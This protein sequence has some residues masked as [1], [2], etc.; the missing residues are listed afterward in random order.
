MAGEPRHDETTDDQVLIARIV[1]GGEPA[2]RAFESL[3]LKHRD[4]VVALAMRFTGDR[5]LALDVMQETFLYVVRKL[6]DP[7]F[8]LTG[9]FMT[10]LYPAVRH[11]SINARQKA[12]RFQ[13]YDAPG[14]VDPGNI[15][16][17]SIDPEDGDRGST[18]GSAAVTIGGASG[19]GGR[20]AMDESLLA[21]LATLPA[22]QREVLILRFVDALSLQEIAQAMG[23]PL[24]TVKSRLH[25]ALNA[26]REDP[27][28]RELLG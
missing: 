22:G 25:H 3:Y 8:A 17:G 16:P 19:A 4:W 10:F 24:G 23:L 20:D 27:R 6:R 11:L 18:T 28:T 12:K 7:G 5:D 15:N 21:V 14:S 13:P 1:A 9:Q 2:S 26:L